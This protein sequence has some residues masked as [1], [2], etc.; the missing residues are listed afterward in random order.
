MPPR[1]RHSP[2]SG[3]RRAVSWLLPS[4]AV[5]VYA[6]M[7]LGYRQGWG[8]LDAFDSWAVISGHDVGVKHPAWVS[9]WE[10]VC[11]VFAP[12]TFRLLAMLAAVAALV[13]RRLRDTLF[14]LVTVEPTGLVTQLAKDLA[15]RP[16]P[17]TAL[18]TASSSSFPSGHALG[19]MV[20]VAALLTVAL[21]VLRG[22]L[23]VAAVLL[24]VLIVA[25]VGVG[26]VALSV[27][28]PSDVVAG[29]VLG[30]LYILLWVRLLRPSGVDPRGPEPQK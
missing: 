5:V 15:D 28:H 22:R 2:H 11:T 14:L 13:K 3:R 23:R 16:R 24:G 26:R 27:H 17:A 1:S 7:W 6:A 19:S 25:A 12:A 18:V 8:W 20:G 10:S 21:P 4:A 30:Y 29:W 9:F